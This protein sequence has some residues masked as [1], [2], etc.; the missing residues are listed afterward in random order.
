MKQLRIG[1]FGAIRGGEYYSS[2]LANDFEIVAIC[3][4]NTELLETSKKRLGDKVALYTDFEDFFQHPMDAVFLSN[5]F[6]E[7]APYAI[8]FLEK[9]IHVLSECLPAATMAECVQLVRA[10]EKSSAIYMFAE[11]YPYMKFNREMRRLCE[12]GTL[13]K[14]LYAE[15]EYNHP[16]SGME[17]GFILQRRWFPEHWRNYCPATYYVTH[18]LGPLML[19]TGALPRRV[20]AFPVV[21]PPREEDAPYAAIYSSESAAMIS[22]MNDDGSVFR[23]TGCSHFG[24]HG[25]AYRICGE[26]GQVENL[27]GMGQQ[28]MLRYNGWDIPEGGQERSLYEPEWNHPKADLIE[29]EGHGGGDFLIAETFR[30]CILE[31]KTPDL[32]VYL[33]TLMASVAI[34]GHRSLL[35]GGVP[36]DLPDF[37]KEEDRAKWEKDTLTPFWG[38]NGEEPSLPAGYIQ[39]YKPSAKQIENY[40]ALIA[41]I[42]KPH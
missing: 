15:G 6:H 2:F 40:N 24:A 22:T 30:D 23:F 35:E 34:L 9:G 8:R 1:I 3:D 5:Y 17:T 33:A 10:A 7:H 38:P 21:N 18:S 28:I 42:N 19:A 16:L 26:K 32:N 41:T 13:G 25:N 31:N 37:R 12:G 4:K 20:S 14:I 29:K 39:D 36:Y 11:N 27:R